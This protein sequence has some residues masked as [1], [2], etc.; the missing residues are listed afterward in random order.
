M[1]SVPASPTGELPA[2]HY[3]SSGLITTE[4]AVLLGD[5]QLLSSVAE[6]AG[7][8]AAPLIE[9][10]GAS[11]ISEEPAEEA[12]ARVGLQVVRGTDDAA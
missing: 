12:F 5:T 8:D 9:L 10:I 7:L 2:T 11:D 1:F 6:S 4:F 3:V